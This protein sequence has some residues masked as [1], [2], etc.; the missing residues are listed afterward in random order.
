MQEIEK[1]YYAFISYQHGD[2][3]WAA[4]LQRS[5]EKYHLPANLSKSGNLPSSIRPIF[6][7]T[8]ELS[9]GVLSAEIMK[10]LECSRHLIVVCSPNSAKSMW[11]DKEVDSYKSL[12]RE[13]CIIPFIIDGE[14]HAA[15]TSLECYP[16]SLLA[17]KNEQELLGININ[18]LGREP[19][20]VKVVAKMLGLRFDTLWQRRRR[21]QKRRRLG[22]I[23]FAASL[24]LASVGIALYLMRQNENLREANQII[25]EQK[26]QAVIIGDS[27]KVAIDSIAQ[28]QQIIEEAFLALN[29]ERNTILNQKK[30][31][32]AAN[33]QLSSLNAD[34]KQSVS[35]FVAKQAASLV[36]NGDA[37]TARRLL[38][39]VLPGPI[40]GYDWPLMKETEEVLYDAWSETP[41]VFLGPKNVVARVA[42]NP[43]GNLIASGD[44]DGDIYL[45]DRFSG[46]NKVLKGH[47]DRVNLLTFTTD[48]TLVSKSL[49]HTIRVWDTDANK[50]KQII[51]L[52]DGMS[53][54]LLS[55]SGEFAIVCI[56]N[57]D[58]HQSV[59]YKYKVGETWR[60]VKE[61]KIP[62]RVWRLSMSPDDSR[63]ALGL[64]SGD[65]CL[66]DLDSNNQPATRPGHPAMV[67]CVAF[68]PDGKLMVSCGNDG[69]IC[70]WDTESLTEQLRIQEDF[71]VCEVAF[72][73]RGSVFFL[74]ITDESGSV[75]HI[76]IR[77]SHGKQIN[78]LQARIPLTAPYLCFDPS[79]RLLCYATDDNRVHV[80]DADT[81]AGDI[82]FSGHD[83]YISELIFAADGHTVLS[84]SWDNTVRLF[85]LGETRMANGF[86]GHTS[87]IESIQYSPDDDYILTGSL[88]ES[89][90]LWDSRTGAIKKEF[91]AKGTVSA[92]FFMANT[93]DIVSFSWGGSATRWDVVSGKKILEL[94]HDDM[95]SILSGAI[96]KEG[97]LIAFGGDD[98]LIRL[99]DRQGHERGSVQTSA[100]PIAMSVNPARDYVAFISMGKNVSVLDTRSCRVVGAYQDMTAS[101]KYSPSGRYLAVGSTSGEITIWDPLL[102]TCYKKLSG[103]NN[104]VKSLA[105]SPDESLLVSGSLDHTVRVWNLR[106][107]ATI[108]RKSC[109]SDIYSVAVSN[110]GLEA[111]YGDDKGNL[112][113]FALPALNLNELVDLTYNTYKGNPLSEEEKK[114]FNL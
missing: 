85:Q 56:S 86:S 80:V 5:L 29:E 81:G 35:R 26:R 71:P 77:D 74:T 72:S 66:L 63:L 79:G 64:W 46:E 107:G 23:C 21:E 20:L 99:Y 17:L 44:W 108:L 69:S 96:D 103:H 12:G 84:G 40:A 55:N 105:F 4:W 47:S 49:D 78:R 24:L 14:P 94:F 10:A 89:V 101:V 34:L 48:R 30:T 41:T 114:R 38:L 95:V 65:I 31:I 54:C 50:E 9:S 57:L 109:D 76:T 73:S 39:E 59:V 100:W 3:K 70:Y 113:T 33:S 82:V 67:T 61:Y 22:W 13:E 91:D 97:E 112:V 27:L 93:T 102:K 75:F 88:D 8:T 98:N 60:K 15:D 83:G 68:S 110:D 32:S 90:K 62:G 92:A 7:D 53:S 25:S 111:A 42:T 106:T 43:K 11:V 19:A 37:L 104:T 18:D 16:K 87:S 1:E 58:D 52:E 28:Q 51:H 2:E 6:R 45:W 36:E